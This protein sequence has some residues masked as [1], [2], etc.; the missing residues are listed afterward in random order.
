MTS[1]LNVGVVDDTPTQRMVLKGLLGESYEVE[2]FP[3]GEAFLAAGRC[4]DAVLL[5][6]EM[7]GIG[8]Y[9]TCRR[10]RAGEERYDTPVI[11]V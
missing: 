10:L 9:E 7:P 11:F 1:K 3:S 4:F 5:D 2:E 6:I 8:G